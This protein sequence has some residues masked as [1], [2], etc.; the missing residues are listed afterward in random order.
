[1]KATMPKLTVTK[2]EHS[3]NPQIKQLR[4]LWSLCSQ[5]NLMYPVSLHRISKIRRRFK[6]TNRRPKM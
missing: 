2:M 1:M 5:S 3:L 6:L 4:R